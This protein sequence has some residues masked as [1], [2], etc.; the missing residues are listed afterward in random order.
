MVIWLVL[1][2][3]DFESSSVSDFFGGDLLE[4]WLHTRFLRQ[5]MDL[6]SN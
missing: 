4:S 1:V 6:G 2:V 5:E 3:P